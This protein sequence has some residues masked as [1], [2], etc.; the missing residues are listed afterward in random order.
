MEEN[1]LGDRNTANRASLDANNDGDLL[2][3]G[4][5]QYEYDGMDRRISKWQD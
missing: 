3:A 1:K 5:W 4:D 2:D